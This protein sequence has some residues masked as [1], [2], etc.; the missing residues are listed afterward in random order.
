LNIGTL[1]S[2]NN[3][4]IGAQCFDEEKMNFAKL[5]GEFQ[6]VFCWSYE[7]LHGFYPSLIKH[8]IPIKEGIKRVRKKQIPINPELEETIRNES[9]NPLKARII[10]PVKF[11]EWVSNLVLVQ[12]TTGQIRLCID[13]CALNRAIIKY[14]FPLPNMEMILQQV[15]GSQKMSLLDG[16]SSYNQIKVKRENKYKTTFISHWGTLTYE[17]IPSRL[18]DESATFKRPVQVA[19]GDLIDVIIHI[20]LDDLILYSKGLSIV[21]KF[22]NICLGPFNIAFVLG[23]NSY[24]L[25]YLQE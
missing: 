18:S 14:H 15:A 2:P 7:D 1:K 23:T 21:S 5:L 10:F 8:A 22:Q 9:E 4:K 11:S 20:Y 6:D 16:F 12:K 25:K 3:V 19:Y 13:F 24:I 17:C